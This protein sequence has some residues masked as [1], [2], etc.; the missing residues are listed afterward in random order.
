MLLTELYEGCL[1]GLGVDTETLPDKL[2]TTYLKAIA[3]ACGCDMSET[4]TLQQT[5]LMAVAENIATAAS[6]GVKADCGSFTPADYHNVVVPHNLGVAPD[7]IFIYGYSSSATNKTQFIAGASQALYDAYGGVMT[8]QLSKGS[9]TSSQQYILTS[10]VKCI[11]ST[12]TGLP[13]HSANAETFTIGDG[14]ALSTSLT[15]QYYAFGGLT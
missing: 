4:D 10:Y 7:F 1:T 2:E 9:S 12:S 5:M 3:E 8:M 6:G 13:I 14:A 11:D 15:Y